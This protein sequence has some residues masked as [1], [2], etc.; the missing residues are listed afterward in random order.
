MDTP[1]DFGDNGLPLPLFSQLPLTPLIPLP[2]SYDN[3][4]VGEYPPLAPDTL[5]QQMALEQQAPDP[6]LDRPAPAPIVRET[7]RARYR[8]RASRARQVISTPTRPKLLPQGS[9]CTDLTGL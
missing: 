7:P 5:E 4:D 3:Y 1:Y 8:Q 2:S 9:R 6:T